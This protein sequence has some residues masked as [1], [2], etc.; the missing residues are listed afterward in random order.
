[1][2]VR[3]NRVLV[4]GLIAIGGLGGCAAWPAAETANIHA[5]PKA[6]PTRT[7]TDFTAALTCMRDLVAR[8]GKTL[9]VTSGNISDSYATL[10][11]DGRQML[12]TAIGKMAPGQQITYVEITRSGAAQPMAPGESIRSHKKTFPLEDPRYSIE[13]AFTEVAKNIMSDRAGAG[14]LTDVFRIGGTTERSVGHITLDLRIVDLVGHTVVNK[15]TTSTTI[16]LEN[17]GSAFTAGARIATA[18]FEFDFS[19]DRNEAESRVAR[20]LIELGTIEVF[21]KLLDLDYAPCISGVRGVEQRIQARKE[22]DAASPAA[23]K[24][25]VWSALEKHYS[26][27]IVSEEQFARKALQYKTEAGLVPTGSTSDFDI[28]ESLRNERTPPPG[29]TVPVAVAPQ[30]PM[31]PPAAVGP[32][33]ARLVLAWRRDATGETPAAAVP[34]GE[35]ANIL[36]GVAGSAY[37]RCYYRSVDDKVYRV[38]PNSALP[39]ERITGSGEPR[40][41]RAKVDTTT[42]GMET[43]ICFASESSLEHVVPGDVAGFQPIPGLRN[44]QDIRAAFVGRQVTSAIAHV[45][46]RP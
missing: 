41:I 18:G 28:Y 16:V 37:V 32:P 43:A 31:A 7:V 8:S 34:R 15:T 45:E 42:I 22:Y 5:A 17:R 10:K 39:D 6:P 9:L 2:R 35:S 33:S 14:V 29:V 21:G 23:R 36:V 30:P 25:F 12:V 24:T 11:V 4:S 38:F 19:I 13:G 3:V 40:P 44:I 46:V 26:E 20:T 27:K 1:M